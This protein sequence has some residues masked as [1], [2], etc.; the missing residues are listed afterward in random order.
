MRWLSDQRLGFF[1]WTPQAGGAPP[2]PRHPHVV[3]IDE[4]RRAM[5]R[6]LYLFRAAKQAPAGTPPFSGGSLDAWPA[7]ALDA[8]ALLE[9]EYAVVCEMW[10]HKQRAP[11]G[12]RE[13]RRG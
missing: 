6:E 4:A 11:S 8:F 13:V 2:Q 1:G 5:E 3:D 7:A 9:A 12:A 10:A